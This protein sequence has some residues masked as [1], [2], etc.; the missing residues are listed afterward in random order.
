M[1]F[2]RR[3]EGIQN[4]QRQIILIERLIILPGKLSAIS[5]AIASSSLFLSVD[6]NRFFK[7]RNA[8]IAHFLQRS[9]ALLAFRSPFPRNYIGKIFFGHH[10]KGLFYL[11]FPEKSDKC[12]F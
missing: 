9:I 2:V 11:Y 1:I 5:F 7:D 12:Y 10:D 4:F 6:K 8:Q 3:F